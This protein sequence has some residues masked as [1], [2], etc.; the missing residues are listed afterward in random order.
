MGLDQYLRAKKYTS[1]TFPGER[2]DLFQSLLEMTGA[3]AIA[4]KDFGSATVEVTVVYWRKA[5]AIHKWFVDNCQGGVD[6]CRE[7]YV[8]RDELKN[9]LETCEKVIDSP[10][11]ASEL[12]PTGEGFFFGSTDYDSWYFQDLERTVE[13]LRY[14]LSAVD[15]N[16][17]FYY[18]S[19]W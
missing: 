4:E 14:L 3:T 1:P 15:D 10:K 9:L 7:A 2:A 17:D 8:G 12:L 19:S 5:N 11:L 18:D 16:W 6:D 13:R